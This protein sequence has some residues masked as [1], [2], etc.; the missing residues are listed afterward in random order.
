MSLSR[1]W[2]LALLFAQDH[3]LIFSSHLCSEGRC[4]SSLSS[5]QQCRVAHLPGHGI[6]DPV[7]CFRQREGHLRTIA[8]LSEAHLNSIVS[9]PEGQGGER[10]EA[11]EKET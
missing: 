3:V 7:R 9:K 2:L 1:V 10:K 11:R 6:L 4:P 8:S 5:S